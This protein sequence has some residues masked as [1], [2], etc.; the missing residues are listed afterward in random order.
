LLRREM[1]RVFAGATATVAAPLAL[2]AKRCV[3]CGSMDGVS[4]AVMFCARSN[5]HWVELSC[6]GC[7]ARLFPSRGGCIHRKGSQVGNCGA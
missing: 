1:L 2:A 4:R 5:A 7:D 6:D 3:A